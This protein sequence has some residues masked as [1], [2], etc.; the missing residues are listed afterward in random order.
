MCEPQHANIYRIAA[1]LGFLILSLLGSADA[2]QADA[3][4]AGVAD[5]ELERHIEQTYGM[6]ALDAVRLHLWSMYGTYERFAGDLGVPRSAVERFLADHRWEL[7]H[8]PALALQNRDLSAHDALFASSGKTISVRALVTTGG[9]PAS[10]TTEASIGCNSNEIIL[11]ITC[12][13]P[14]VDRLTARASAANP[15]IDKQRLHWDGHIVALKNA[16]QNN[17]VQLNAWAE[18]LTPPSQSVLLDDCILV[19]L[20]PVAIGKDRSYLFPATFIPNPAKW[21]QE[22][23][24]PTESRVFLEGAYYAIAVNPNG[25]VLDAFFDPWEGGTVCPAWPS[26]VRVAT[27]KGDGIWQVDLRIPWSSLKPIVNEDS[28]WGVDLARIR[29]AGDSPEDVTRSPQS[30]LVRYD[31]ANSRPA[32]KLRALPDIS[33]SHLTTTDSVETFPSLGEWAAIPAIND[34]YDNRSARKVEDIQARITHDSDTLYVRFDCR[35]QNIERLRVVTSAEEHAEYGEESRRCNYLDRRE[36][37]GLDWGD[38][39]EVILAPNLD[40]ADRFHGGMFTFLVN[41]RSALLERYYD[42]YGMF[43]VSPHPQWS[44]GAKVRVTK[45]NDT[46]SVELAIPLGVLT[47]MGNI[48]ST[49]GLNLH[50]AK[51]AQVTGRGEKHLC[52]S[53]TQPSFESGAW[54]A[55]LKSLRDG[56]RLGV[57]RIDAEQFEVRQHVNCPNPAVARSAKS[58]SRKPADRDRQSDRLSSVCFVDPS[59]G[60]AI[61]G[62]GTILH[63][64]D[65]GLTWRQQESGTDFILEKVFFIDEHH[66]WAIGGWPRDAAV[67][68]LG[69]M[70]VILATSDGGKHWTK[71]IDGE[72]SWLKDVFFLDRRHGWA[73][74]EYGTILRTTDGGEHWR[75]IKRTHTPSWLYGVAM[76]DD[77]RGFAVGHDETILR[78]NDGGETWFVRQSPVPRQPNG[79]PA[80]Y[81]AVA[82]A[83]ARRGWIVGDGGTILQT[84]DGGNSWQLDQLDLPDEVVEMASFEDLTV[85]DDGTAWAV[86]PVA[87]LSKRSKESHWRVA[88]SGG[89]GWHRAACFLDASTGWLVGERGLMLH[90]S[91]G[92]QTWNR[93]CESDRS[94]GLLYATAHDHHLNS[95][96]LSA[97]SEPCD[98]AYVCFCRGVRPFELD[99]DYNRHMVAASAM[100][101]GI[102]VVHS[103]VEFCWRERDLPHCIAQRYQNYDG[104]EGIERRLVA[105]IRALR[106]QILVA[107]QPVIQEGYYAHGVGE[108]ARALIRAFDSAADPTK[109]PGLV[110]LGLQPYAPQKLYI[111]SNWANHMYRIHPPTLR[112]PPPTDPFSKR[113]GMTFGEAK[114]RSRYCFWG[115]LDRQ[116]PPKE[117]LGSGAWNLHLKKWRGE[118]QSPERS[119]YD[120]EG[121]Q[122]GSQQ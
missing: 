28:V 74:G 121:R 81:R 117:S 31:V 73:V 10:P 51:S 122:S 102:P 104:I 108:V 17:L 27:H 48:S 24:P 57:M 34:F 1:P 43:N 26:K 113:L 61:G 97:V 71:Q 19:L 115:M 42:S 64:A 84:T 88:S 47:T 67:S 63:T 11:S 103:F 20:T 15:L 99:G 79:W 59:H 12:H 95:G 101:A 62:M 105:M 52:W 25:A 60:W 94:M 76:I 91:D 36:H 50:R 22:T 107:E 23:E 114:A 77:L 68:L 3:E 92:G 116:L 13:E 80:A 9:R 89:L 6:P 83:D 2:Q 33:V 106:P 54:P 66:G 119:L 5:T 44:S 37:Y 55:T 21:L 14:N 85:S 8:A 4:S 56:R 75:Q 53:T 120:G 46:W 96:P 49:W 39:V 118:I 18:K 29:R 32:I 70:G 82:F 90:T 100:A 98:T 40:F 78:T 111:I 65:G 72:A 86:S 69:G 45:A 58:A 110:E 112:V 93:Q 87:L 16:F 41:S 109:F 7:P 30:T 38:Y 35:E